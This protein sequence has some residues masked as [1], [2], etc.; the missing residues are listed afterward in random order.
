[1][2]CSSGI[3]KRNISKQQQLICCCNSWICNSWIAAVIAGYRLMFAQD[4]NLVLLDSD[5]E[6][7]SALIGLSV[8][9]KYYVLYSLLI[10]I[11]CSFLYLLNI[12]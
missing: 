9:L 4:G 6:L 11:S 8:S 5:R 1:L 7:D 10:L 3:K 2:K 12:Y